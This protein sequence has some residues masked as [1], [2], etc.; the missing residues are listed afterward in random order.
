[1]AEGSDHTQPSGTSREQILRDLEAAGL[2]RLLEARSPPPPSPARRKAELV[3][4]QA[5]TLLRQAAPTRR[6]L[7]PTAYV[8]STAL[9]LLI[10][11]ALYSPYFLSGS[12]ASGY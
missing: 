9:I 5:E 3:A 7:A 6:W 10:Y 12:G 11:F 2:L 8:L 1:V 4:Q